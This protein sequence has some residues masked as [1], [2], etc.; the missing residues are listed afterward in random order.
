MKNYIKLLTALL[1]LPLSV[2]ATDFVGG[3]VVGKWQEW[4]FSITEVSEGVWLDDDGSG[5]TYT[6]EFIKD[7]KDESLAGGDFNSVVVDYG[8]EAVVTEEPVADPIGPRQYDIDIANE[9]DT[10]GAYATL[11]NSR[12]TKHV[13]ENYEELSPLLARAD[14]LENN[15]NDVSASLDTAV[16]DIRN[17][18]NITTTNTNAIE[19]NSQ[20]VDSL[21]ANDELFGDALVSISSN[22]VR[23]TNNIADNTTAINSNTLN[24]ADHEG[25][26]DYNF[27]S[28]EIITQEVYSLKDTVNAI[29]ASDYRL[30]KFLIPNRDPSLESSWKSGEDLFA[31]E[32]EA[33]RAGNVVWKYDTDLAANVGKDGQIHKGYT[34]QQ[35]ETKSE[36]YVD[37]FVGKDGKTYKK[38]DTLSIVSDHRDMIEQNA[39]DI[40][41]NTAGIAGALASDNVTYSQKE[42]G[43]ISVGVGNYGGE[44]AIAVGGSVRKNRLAVRVSLSYDSQKNVGTSAGVTWQ[45]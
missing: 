39:A 36:Y 13:V 28:T 1:L 34:A 40:K 20:N 18:A 7:M 11:S 35:W 9:A 26:I 41:G 17:N 33:S 31:N 15:L 44:T 24:I 38:V 21:L 16:R 42:G 25:R 27:R 22:V 2:M 45:F 37:S 14:N 10:V 19:V 32:D 4:N 30:K 8:I 5:R 12:L 6:D 43:S 29:G 3:T 23:N